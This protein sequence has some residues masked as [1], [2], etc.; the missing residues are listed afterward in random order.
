MQISAE[1]ARQLKIKLGAVKRTTKE[2]LYYFDEKT[3]EE[4]RLQSMKESNQDAYDIKQQ[5]NVVQETCVM[6]PA[7]KKSLEEHLG[8]L[9]TF[10]QELGESLV[11]GTEQKEEVDSILKA[12]GDALADSA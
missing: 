10:V 4:K 3:R 1:N 5:E 2:Y 7:T 6:I 12:A 8:G 9:Q 11:P